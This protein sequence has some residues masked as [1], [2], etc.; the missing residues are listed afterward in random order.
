MV[1]AHRSIY[2]LT[3]AS[4]ESAAAL[5][6]LARWNAHTSANHAALTLAG[7]EHHDYLESLVRAGSSNLIK[8]K[9]DEPINT[10][11]N[12]PTRKEPCL[13]LRWTRTERSQ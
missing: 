10:K 12:N 7:V 5:T 8:E 6:T 11:M 9:T 13:F 3:S 4:F 2:E 1:C